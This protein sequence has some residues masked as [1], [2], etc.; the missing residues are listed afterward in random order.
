[1]SKIFNAQKLFLFELR[2]HIEH[3]DTEFPRILLKHYEG[4]L[5]ELYFD[6]IIKYDDAER[7]MSNLEKNRK[8]RKLFEKYNITVPFIHK[9]YTLLDYLCC[10]RGR[11]PRYNLLL[12]ELAKYYPEECNY[13]VNSCLQRYAELLQQVSVRLREAERLS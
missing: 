2:E 11:L 5:F 1:V 3:L 6:A 12:R 4:E 13:E 8:F 10:P 9:H 7:A